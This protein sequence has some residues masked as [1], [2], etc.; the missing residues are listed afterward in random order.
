MMWEIA[1]LPRID[2]PYNSGT[3]RTCC[4]GTSAVGCDPPWLFR[5]AT[6]SSRTPSHCQSDLPRIERVSGHC[7]TR[8]ERPRE[9]GSRE[10]PHIR[11]CE[12]LNCPLEDTVFKEVADNPSL[13]SGNRHMKLTK[14]RSHQGTLHSSNAFARR[15]NGHMVFAPAKAMFP[16]DDRRTLGCAADLDGQLVEMHVDPR[17]PS[18]GALGD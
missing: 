11:T 17:T 7:R 15:Q 9:P 10:I 12:N 6:P 8:R 3:R 4:Q 14:Q 18:E 1:F 13:I 2:K 16:L 5:S